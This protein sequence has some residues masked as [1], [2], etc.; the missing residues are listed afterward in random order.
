V[1]ISFV[2]VLCN[3][4]SDSF[5]AARTT[6]ARQRLAEAALETG[7][8]ADKLLDDYDDFCT[9]N[10]HEMPESGDPDDLWE[11]DVLFDGSIVDSIGRDGAIEYVPDYR[12][13]HLV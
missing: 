10:N 1:C 5:F 3:T 4:L 8:H 9:G 12:S 6:T 2:L 7:V 13:C 11:D